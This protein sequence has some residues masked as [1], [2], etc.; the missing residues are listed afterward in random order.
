MNS[1]RTYI[2]FAIGLFA[3]LLLVPKAPIDP[4]GL[5]NLYSLLRLFLILTVLQIISYVIMNFFKGHHGGFLLGFFGGLVSSTALSASLAKQSHRST[6]DEIRLLSLSYLSALLGMAAEGLV[7]V[8]VGLD[9]MHWSLVW[10]FAG[11]LAVTIVL[12]AGRIRRLREITFQENTLPTMNIK[13]LLTLGFVVAGF[14]ILS[15]VLQN[16]LG[17]SGQ[18]LLTFLVC[19]FEFHGSVIGNVALHQQ[20]LITVKTL[21]NL[22]AVGLMA[23]Y[24]AKM[25]LVISLGDTRLRNKVVKYSILLIFS[26]GIGWGM[27]VNFGIS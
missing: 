20:E 24:L 19:L 1:L 26:L 5:I 21:G 25:V 3:V 23:S 11:P 17:N 9:E 10:I 22:L 2:F 7:L 6:E 15:K 27:S 18:F 4:W 14:L 16:V 13:S 12:L 8:Y